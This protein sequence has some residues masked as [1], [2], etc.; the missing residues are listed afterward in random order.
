MTKNTMVLTL[1]TLGAFVLTAMAVPVSKSAAQ[2]FSA[3][4]VE[5]SAAEDKD[6][7]KT[8]TKKVAPKVQRA[9]VRTAP[10]TTTIHRAPPK[11]NTTQQKTRVNVGTKKIVGPKVVGPKVVGPKINSAKVG[12]AK[13][14]KVFVPKGTKSKQVVFKGKLRSFPKAGVGHAVIGGRN[15]SVWRGKHRVRHRNGWYTFVGLG[16]LTAI[17]IGANHYYPYAYISASEDYCDGLTEDGCQM[18]WQEVDTEEGDLIP[19]CVAYCPWQ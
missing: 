2:G 1:C 7:K 5:L 9:P 19:Q 8:G 18:V 3:T 11:L 6:K 10:R 16:A 17:A 4:T 13:T 15:F 14:V 12:G